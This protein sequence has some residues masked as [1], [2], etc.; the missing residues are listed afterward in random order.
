LTTP[1][2]AIDSEFKPE[3]NLTYDANLINVHTSN[4]IA[5][6]DNIVNVYWW[7]TVT[8]A[9]IDYDPK[10]ANATAKALDPAD[11]ITVIKSAISDANGMAKMYLLSVILNASNPT[12]EPSEPTYDYTITAEKT[13]WRFSRELVSMDYVDYSP[14]SN[15]KVFIRTYAPDLTLLDIEF[16]PNYPADG[17]EVNIMAIVENS[18]PWEKV[19]KIIDLGPSDSWDDTHVL[20]GSVL[21]NGTHYLMWYW[22]HDGSRWRIGYATSTDGINWTKYSDPVLDIGEPGSLDDSHVYA[23]SVI[24]DEGMY[25]MWY[26]AHDG[27]H[28][29]IA[30]ATSP[31]GIN[32]TKHG[33][34]LDLGVGWKTWDN[35]QVHSPA[36][37]RDGKQYK[38]WYAGYAHYRYWYYWRDF[39]H[40]WRIGYATSSDGINWKKHP[41]PVLDLGPTIWDNRHL[42]YPYVIKDGNAYRMWYTGY[43][44]SGRWT[45]SYALSNDG[46]NWRKQSVVLSVG[47][48]GTWDDHHVHTPIVRKEANVYKMWYGGIDPTDDLNSSN[49]T[50]PWHGDSQNSSNWRIGYATTAGG[51][52]ASD[53]VVQFYLG[54]PDTGTQIG[55]NQ[56]IPFIAAGDAGNASVSL[57]TTGLFGHNN[58]F[59]RIDPANSVLELNED[60]NVGFEDL[61]VGSCIV[62][63]NDTLIIDADKTC[64]NVYILENATFIVTNDATLT[65][66]E[67]IFVRGNGTLILDN[68]TMTTTDTSIMYL[69]D[70]ANLTGIN[71]KITLKEIRSPDQAVINLDA[72][73][74]T[75]IWRVTASRVVNINSSVITDPS[76]SP[77]MTM[78]AVETV[79]IKGSTINAYGGDAF[80]AG[81]GSI[82][83]N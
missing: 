83:I 29:R 57:N 52:N 36:V 47:R 80:H 43:G 24:Y 76:F 38:M 33:V 45:N 2:W 10:I 27:S 34:V 42:L 74:V 64:L 65:V 53:I 7:L 19:G 75:A 40:H 63:G 22:G 77:I 81:S 58:I 49:W 25:K 32:W 9:D 66:A 44:S 41:S 39:F 21:F 8:V 67:N 54:D 60:N 82:T 1:L 50:W 28:T 16:D 23:P 26:T 3:L 51:I 20:P 61:E 78:N 6:G 31:D 13:G 18:L 37:I 62:V 5:S 11:N 35:W 46:I 4:V 14:A 48:P 71:S 79:N 70:M 69:F 55:I 12:H 73:D 30:Y 56:T 15:K 72:S 68:G 59:V 17:D